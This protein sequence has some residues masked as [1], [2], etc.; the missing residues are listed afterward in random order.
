[1]ILLLFTAI[2]KRISEY[3]FTENRYF[4]LVIACWIL[5]MTLYILVSKRK[6]LRYFPMILT[7][8]SLLASFGFW[9]AF[10][11]SER[12][13]VKQ[14][15]RLFAEIK[16]KDFK[17][18]RDEDDQFRSIIRYLSKRNAINKTTPLFGFNPE[19]TY[20][21]IS[22]WTMA[23]KLSDT[24]KI[25]VIYDKNDIERNR[26]G[27]FGIGDLNTVYD[28]SGY[29]YLKQMNFY[30][31]DTLVRKSLHDSIKGYTMYLNFKESSFNILKDSIDIHKIN[32]NPLIIKLINKQD[33]YDIPP[34]LLTVK[35]EFDDI[36]IKLIFQSMYINNEKDSLPRIN[37][38]SAYIF[39][40]LKENA[41]QD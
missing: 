16:A 24:L 17:I 3:G 28:I 19:E 11:V 15:S 29:D 21:D 7:I 14:F 41:Q 5:A 13:Q 39:L 30:E 35:Q 2:Y 32:L 9:G 33:R 27:Y 40:K 25:E 37:N 36:N 10:S 34:S 4:V 8:I 18:T 23:S 26:N 22:D 1:M 31:I 38:A 6:Q 12:S 20:K